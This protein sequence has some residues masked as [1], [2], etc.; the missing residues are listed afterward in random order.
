MSTVASTEPE[1]AKEDQ[2]TVVQ[3]GGV[4]REQ[5]NKKTVQNPAYGEV[6]MT[7]GQLSGGISVVQTRYEPD[8]ADNPPATHRRLVQ[9][10]NREKYYYVVASS[11][12]VPYRMVE[13][14]LAH[15]VSQHSQLLPLHSLLL[16]VSRLE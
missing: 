2:S 6:R 13:E 9:E 5:E 15:S 7:A 3:P 14:Y 4:V 12:L 8:T 10:V 11:T 1:Q 16:S